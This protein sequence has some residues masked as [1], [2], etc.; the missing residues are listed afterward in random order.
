MKIVK[1]E[2]SNND[3]FEKICNWNYNWWG[4]RNNNSLEEVKCYMKH[5]LCMDKIPQTF[6]A[7][8][9]NEPVGMYQFAM[10]DDLNS[11]PDIYPWLVNVFVDERRRGEGI[12]K[13]LMNTVRENAK[14]LNIHELYLYTKHV[15]LYEKYGWKFIEEVDTFRS[16]SPVERLYR[17]TID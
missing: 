9:N 7:I 2:S 11:R 13:D 1:L 12:C 10:S 17:L 5:C 4:K 14:K 8:D 15:G 3:I 16:D 6:V